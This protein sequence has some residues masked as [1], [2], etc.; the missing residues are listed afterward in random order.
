MN[1]SEGEA[2]GDAAFSAGCGFII[3][4]TARQPGYEMPHMP[5]LP[6]WPRRLRSS[7]SI[8]SYVSLDSSTSAGA[9]FNGRNGRITSNSPSE[10]NFRVRPG[11]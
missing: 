3:P 7:H 8:V 2:C 4:I 10:P 5:T 6:L 9:R 11:T 1:M